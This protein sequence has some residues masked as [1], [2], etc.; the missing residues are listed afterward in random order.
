MAY[1][2]LAIT[3][4]AE[5]TATSA[6]KASE[7][8]TKLIPSIIVL[9]GYGI[10]FYFM[11][12]ILRTIPIGITYALWSGLGIVLVTIVGIFLYKQIPD[13]AAV[14]GMSLIVSGVVII[15]IFSKTIDH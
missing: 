8:F 14:I 6:L 4:I 3:I 13:T 1:L 5:V 7:E 15:H 10:S 2:Y 9:I 11:T 12:L